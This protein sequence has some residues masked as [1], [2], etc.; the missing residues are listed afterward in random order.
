MQLLPR[1]EKRFDGE[2]L[3]I[4]TINFARENHDSDS[5]LEV[6]LLCYLRLFPARI[7][8]TLVD[9]FFSFLIVDILLITTFVTSNHVRDYTPTLF[10]NYIGKI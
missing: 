3:K 10:Y 4:K 6:L 1:E 5:E 9:V 7:F 8:K 2:D